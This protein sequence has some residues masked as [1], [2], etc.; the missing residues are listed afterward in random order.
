LSSAAY[1]SFETWNT[2]VLPAPL[3]LEKY[4]VKK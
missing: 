1:R 2:T 4:T 3:R